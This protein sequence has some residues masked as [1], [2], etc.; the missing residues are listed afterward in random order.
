VGAT[1]S[2]LAIVSAGMPWDPAA[3]EVYSYQI[4]FPTHAVVADA[5]MS[6]E[7]AASM[8]PTDGYDAA[9]FARVQQAMATASAV[10]VT[11]EHYDHMGGAFVGPPPPKNLRLTPAQRDSD[12]IFRPEI[13]EDQRAG[14]ALLPDEP[15]QALAPG[16]VLIKAR[17]HTPG[18]LWVYV[19]RADG[20]EVILTG[21]T[22]WLALNI[23]REQGPPRFA[24]MLMGG[25]RTELTCQLHTLKTLPP[26]VAVMPGHDPERMRA[27]TA[28]GV[29]APGFKELLAAAP[30][31]APEPPTAP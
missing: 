15:Y 27:L 30:A 24:A 2:P 7:Q 1:E 25:D 23:E 3:F 8:G 6:L 11:H 22:A 10:V 19:A 5:G 29:F 13:P 20:A 17:G 14:I 9:A 28:K 4:V 31:P 21:D 26:E 16:V 12:V 18:S